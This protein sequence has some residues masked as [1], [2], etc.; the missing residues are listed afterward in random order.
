MNPAWQPVHEKQVSSIQ[1]FSEGEAREV[2]P[3]TNET[4]M[5]SHTVCR[6]PAL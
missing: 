2:E 3:I 5:H 4:T 1:R 6:K